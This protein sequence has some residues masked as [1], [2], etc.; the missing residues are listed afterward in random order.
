MV[1]LRLDRANRMVTKDYRKGVY[2]WVGGILQSGV[3]SRR[4]PACLFCLTKICGCLSTALRTGPDGRALIRTAIAVSL[5]RTE[6][7]NHLYL[8]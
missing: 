6:F 4:S 5:L 1:I 8:G 7:P 3:S 2:K